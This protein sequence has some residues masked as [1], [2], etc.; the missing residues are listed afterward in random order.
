MLTEETTQSERSRLLEVFLH[1]VPFEEMY[2]AAGHFVER[3][4][5]LCQ[6]KTRLEKDLAALLH[7]V[8]NE[9]SLSPYTDLVVGTLRFVHA[10]EAHGVWSAATAV[11]FLS[12]LLR[13]NARHLTAYDLVTFHNRGA[14][15]PDALLLDEVLKDYLSRCNKQPG[16]FLDLPGDFDAERIVKRRRRR[17]LRQ[18]YLL[19]RR[20]ESHPVPDQ[21]TSPGENM[22]V[23][24]ASHP[25]VPEE[26]LT[27]PSS[28]TKRLFAGDPLTGLMTPNADAVLRQSIA[29]FSH[30]DE[31]RELGMALFLDRP[32]GVGKSAMEPNAT[33]LLSCEAFSH[34]IA[35]ER[36]RYLLQP[37]GLLSPPDC[38]TW[39][40]ALR[41][42][43]QLKGLAIEAIG[44]PP[45]PGVISLS[46][47][48]RAAPDF[49]FLRT[50]AGTLRQLF[51][52]YD[53]APLTKR[54]RLALLEQ[55]ANLLLVRDCRGV[56]V[57]HDAV[58]RPRLEMEVETS[59]GYRRRG[60]QEVSAAG[61]R[62]LRVWEDAGENELPVLRE[63]SAEPVVV[64]PRD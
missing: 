28:R 24:P 32:L 22:R 35:M 23:L 6:G 15:Y 40:R 61:L 3:F 56:L 34:S 46:D 5:A 2:A 38:D 49:V 41:A 62:V 29:D 45:C 44:G 64:G 51:D 14:N 18:G 60:G 33:L 9:V 25:R 16:L 4:S 57:L 10:L 50:T 11:D 21:P 8:F 30:P 39:Q 13:Q 7:S 52:Q 58:H 19:R 36:L 63:L 48:R 59:R 42:D 55:P 20:Y 43:T 1:A 54:F 37:L 12:C 31:L 47:A 26:Q 53:F 17:A 27:D